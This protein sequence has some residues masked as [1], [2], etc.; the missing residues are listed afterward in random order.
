MDINKIRNDINCSQIYLNHAAA[1]TPP[2]PVIS[3]IDNYYNMIVKYGAKNDWITPYGWDSLNK[4]KAAIGKLIN[5]GADEIAFTNNGSEAIST[6]VN[7]MD[8][9]SDDNVVVDEI[10]FICNIAP[11]LYIK[12]T[13]G[14][15]VRLVKAEKP[16]FI[17]LEHLKQIVDSKTRLVSISHAVNA[18]GTVQP[19]K[20]IAKIAHEKG[21]LLLLDAATS[22]GIVDID[23]KDLACDFMTAPGRKLLRGPSG[24]GFFYIRKELIPSI[25]PLVIGWKFG[26][27]DFK[28]NEYH[29]A[30]NIDRFVSGEPNIPGIM[31][32]ERAIQYIFEIGGMKAIE[33]R[34]K[35]LTDYL[36]DA[37]HE[38]PDLEMYGPQDAEKRAGIVSFNIKNIPHDEIRKHLYQNG[39]CLKSGHFHNPGA[40]KMFHTDGVVRF[41]LHYTN[42]K[43]EIDKVTKYLKEYKK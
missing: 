43:E 10:G 1:S 42:T 4:V 5:A 28:N 23:V 20:E 21:A 7:G 13:R 15:E 31:G 37:L 30:D 17:D 11:L 41:S 24:T 3:E 18:I 27:W 39:V 25:E 38:V 2:M 12:K 29:V 16:G 40:L 9:N 34:V 33:E 35:E 36:I 14:I 22:V 26:K 8:F 6:I 19:A 32:L